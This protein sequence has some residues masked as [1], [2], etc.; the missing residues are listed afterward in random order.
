MG[1]CM[2]R[3]HDD[4]P[5]LCSFAALDLSFRRVAAQS[6]E[7]RVLQRSAATNSGRTSN[8]YLETCLEFTR[9][10]V[11]GDESDGSPALASETMAGIA[12]DTLT[13]LKW[14]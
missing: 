10:L 14:Y 9:V 7:Q 1:G 5:H 6:I 8:R 4:N 3:A 11:V 13:L 12:N 2:L